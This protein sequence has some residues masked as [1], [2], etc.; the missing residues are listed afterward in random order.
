MIIVILVGGIS[1][2]E[3][4]RYLV[5]GAMKWDIEQNQDAGRYVTKVLSLLYSL[6]LVRSL[7]D[8]DALMATLLDIEMYSYRVRDVYLGQAEKQ[9]QQKD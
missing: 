3:S 9:K 1:L 6:G 8:N 5:G 4:L 7:F 2:I